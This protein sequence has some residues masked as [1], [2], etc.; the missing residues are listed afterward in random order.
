MPVGRPRKTT[1]ELKLAGVINQHSSRKDWNTSDTPYAID[2]QRQAPSNY[3]PETKSAWAA[4][5]KVKLVQGVLSAEDEGTVRL[6]FDALDDTYRMQKQIDE[7]YL[8]E[9]LSERLA[10]AEQRKH[11]KEMVQVRNMHSD[12]FTRLALRFG[13]T[14]T[15]RS[16][17]A[18]KEKQELSPMLQLLNEDNA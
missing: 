14:P 8:S 13:I 9:N 15:E 11:L 7:F 10:D 4:F 6:M 3:L 18:V 17:L 1:A 12:A 2:T 16:R 5:M